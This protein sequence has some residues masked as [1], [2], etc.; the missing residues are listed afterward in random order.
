MKYLSML[1]ILFC[2][3]CSPPGS[4]EGH[5]YIFI[6]RRPWSGQMAIAHAGHCTAPHIFTKEES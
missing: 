6:S 3:G 4:E 2:I 5:E 1:V